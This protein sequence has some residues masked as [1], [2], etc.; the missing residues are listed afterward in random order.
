MSAISQQRKSPVIKSM[1]LIVELDKHDGV[2]D[3]VTDSHD[4]RVIDR[5][6]E[7][8]K[9]P[10]SMDKYFNFQVAICL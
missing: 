10:R 7:S 8:F 2:G 4:I 3:F 1:E 5:L 9:L 6:N